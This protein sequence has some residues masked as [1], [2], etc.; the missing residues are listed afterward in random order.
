MSASNVAGATAWLDELIH[1]DPALNAELF[2]VLTERQRELGLLHDDRPICP[3]LRPLLLS[4][5]QYERIAAA[6]QTLAGAFERLAEA[7]LQDEKILAQLGLTEKEEQMA[8]FDPGYQ[9]LCVTSRLDAFLAGDE[10]TFLE[11]NAE[12]PAGLA[13]QMQLEKLLY[14][15]PHMREFL[16]ARDTWQPAPHE[17]LLRALLETYRDWGG[18]EAR[19]N[20]AIV[21]WSGVSTESEFHIL[22]EVFERAGYPAV[23]ADPRE[24][25]F[26][27]AHLYAGD[28]RIDIFYKRVIIHEFLDKFDATHPLAQAYAA[29]KVCMANSFRSK[30]AHKK[31]GFAILSD[32]RYS[33][34][35]T[36]EQRDCIRRHIPWTRRAREGRTDFRGEEHELLT[37][38]RRER[39]SLVLKPNDDYGGHGIVIGWETTESEWDAAIENALRQ[40]YV[41]QFRAPVE[42]HSVP[43]YDDTGRI[44]TEPMIIDFDP[45]LFRNEAVGGMVR[46][47]AT[48]LCNVSSGGG[49][50]ALLVLE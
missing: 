19:P 31:A 8:R 7:S 10:F 41:A 43:M 22:R 18:A 4:R 3:F 49:V 33:Y 23:I 25:T 27:G 37:I 2:A 13:D 20:I 48:S 14:D 30:L 46:L 6:A 24:L 39:E 38:L 34:L 36:P 29:G 1:Q 26:D 5:P 45:F 9:K 21:D 11:Y 47:S 17:R 16:A 35:F 44:V 32:E 15:L 40:D 12:S 42:K 28:F 50:T